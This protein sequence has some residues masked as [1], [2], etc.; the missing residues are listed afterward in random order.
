[1]MVVY[2][3]SFQ[4]RKE[5]VT[6]NTNFIDVNAESDAISKSHKGSGA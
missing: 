5:A 1:M 6:V 4:E 2:N 3:A